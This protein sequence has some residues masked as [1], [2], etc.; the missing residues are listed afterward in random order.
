MQDTFLYSYHVP[1]RFH[2]KKPWILYIFSLRI[3]REQ[4]VPDSSNRSLYLTKLFIFSNLEGSSGGNQ[5]PDGSIGLSPSPPSLPPPPRQHTTR[6]TQRQRHRDRDTE[7]K[8]ESLTFQY[9]LMFFAKHLLYILYYILM[10][11]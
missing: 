4:H 2:R 6:N 8:P 10:L 5:Q 9:G 3:D 1:Q 11:S 7:T